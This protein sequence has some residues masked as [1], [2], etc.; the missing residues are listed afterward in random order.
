MT[1]EAFP[2]CRFYVEIAGIPQAVFTEVSG[3]EI[4]I[5]TFQYEEGGT[6]GYVHQLPGRVKTTNLTFKRGITRSTELMDWCLEVAQGTIKPQN[7]TVVMYDSMGEALT[8]WNFEDAY[9]IKWIGP[10]FASDGS[11]VAIET[12]ELAHSGLKSG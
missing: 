1:Q 9:P 4:E 11:T 6:N 10:Q 7:L 12:L 3:L 8:R 2:N 5:E